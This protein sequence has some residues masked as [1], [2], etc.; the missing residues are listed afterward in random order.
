[1][2]PPAVRAR[3][4]ERSRKSGIP[5][6]LGDGSPDALEVCRAAAERQQLPGERLEHVQPDRENPLEGTMRDRP[7]D[8]STPAPPV[9]LP[10]PG[11]PCHRDD[12]RGEGGS[13]LR[14]G[15]AL[16]RGGSARSRRS[17]VSAQVAP[18]CSKAV[19]AAG[20]PS[21]AA[22]SPPAKRGQPARISMLSMVGILLADQR[23]RAARSRPRLRHTA[24]RRTRACSLIDGGTSQGRLAPGGAGRGGAEGGIP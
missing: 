23:R 16:E 8:D 5:M 15:R 17:M 12:V 6:P 20:L 22:P 7:G 4:V 10:S 3:F 24:A 11:L 9:S 14:D 13:H 21:S 1:M 2:Q 18:G 19:R